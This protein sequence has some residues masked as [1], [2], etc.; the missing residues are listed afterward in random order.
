M[1]CAV[2]TDPTSTPDMTAF[3]TDAHWALHPKVQIRPERFG[4]LLYHFG[5]RRLSFV[6]SLTLLSV[7]ERLA[8]SGSAREAIHDAGV[9]PTQ[10]HSMERAL[11]TLA[12]SEMICR[13]PPATA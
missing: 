9:A 2:S 7:L 13:Q 3:D 11:A 1:A 6:K 5:T 8:D 12:R 4:A 10:A